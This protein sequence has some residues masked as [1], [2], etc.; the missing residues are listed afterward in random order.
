MCEF[1]DCMPSKPWSPLSFHRADGVSSRNFELNLQSINDSLRLE[2]K[3]PD[4]VVNR[5]K[6]KLSTNKSVA[7]SGMDEVIN[8]R[9]I[10][11]K[12]R[13]SALFASYDTQNS[14]VPISSQKTL[15]F[16]RTTNCTFVQSRKGL[17]INK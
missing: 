12:N 16:N 9:V 6:S 13:N 5:F 2:R 7:F 10:K 11:S 8:P 15:D 3:V 1:S 17:S 14:R 4:F